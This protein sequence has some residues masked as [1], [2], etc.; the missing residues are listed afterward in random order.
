VQTPPLIAPVRSSREFRRR[1]A[2]T[3]TSVVLVLLLTGVC[4][5]DLIAITPLFLA[6][7]GDVLMI[8]LSALVVL[9]Q[10]QSMLDA[11]VTDRVTLAKGVSMGFA[12]AV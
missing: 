6:R 7:I 3:T 12:S 4:G 10:A 11:S 9:G 8:Q 2:R 1:P 5:L